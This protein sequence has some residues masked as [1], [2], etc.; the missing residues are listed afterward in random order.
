MHVPHAPTP[1]NIGAGSPGNLL[2]LK[3]RPWGLSQ[4]APFIR[5]DDGSAYVPYRVHLDPVKQTGVY[6]DP[7]TLKPIEAAGKHGSNKPTTSQTV[8]PTGDGQ[9]PDMPNGK[10]DTVTDYEQD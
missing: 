5:Q 4:M 6:T 7:V 8:P 2:T 3:P 1:A 9:D 10:P